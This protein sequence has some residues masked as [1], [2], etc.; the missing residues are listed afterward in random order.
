M[1]NSL[2]QIFF[3]FDIHILFIS[4]LSA[5]RQAQPKPQP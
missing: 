5:D 3:E 4:T 2:N 1:F